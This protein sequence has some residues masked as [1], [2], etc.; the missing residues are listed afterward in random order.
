MVVRYVGILV[1]A[2]FILYLGIFRCVYLF[3]FWYLVAFLVDMYNN[4]DILVGAYFVFLCSEI[5]HYT[6][7]LHCIF[8]FN[9]C[10]AVFGLFSLFCIV[11]CLFV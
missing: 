6:R 10:I 1:Q 2:S 5:W 4:V 9:M 3:V 7:N 11:F 8:L